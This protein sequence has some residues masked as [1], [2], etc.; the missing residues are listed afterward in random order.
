MATSPSSSFEP[1]FH[2]LLCILVL[3]LDVEATKKDFYLIKNDIKI[4][5]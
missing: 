3:Y 4:I 1:N 5:L 2:S